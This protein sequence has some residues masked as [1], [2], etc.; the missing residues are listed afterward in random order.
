MIELVNKIDDA[1]SSKKGLKQELSLRFGI[2]G[3]TPVEIISQAE[4]Q[5]NYLSKS[6]FISLLLNHMKSS[7]QNTFKDKLTDQ[8]LD[9][10][11]FEDD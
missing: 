1:T 5:I 11:D 8:L 10:S 7:T 4:E 3:C 2:H 6:E 9:F